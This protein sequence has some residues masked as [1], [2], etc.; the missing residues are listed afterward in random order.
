MTVW[1]SSDHINDAERLTNNVLAD[2]NS[3]LHYASVEEIEET[4][5]WLR[6]YE[7]GL[8]SCCISWVDCVR[9]PNSRF[10]PKMDTCTSY[11]VQHALVLWAYS[12]HVLTKSWYLSLKAWTNF[13]S[14]N[15]D[16]TCLDFRCCIWQQFGGHD[17]TCWIMYCIT[18]A[19][20]SITKLAHIYMCLALVCLSQ[21]CKT[22][23][24]CDCRIFI[25]SSRVYG[26]WVYIWRYKLFAICYMFYMFSA[27]SQLRP[28]VVW[29]YGSRYST[30]VYRV[31]DLEK[32][33]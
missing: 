15:V 12:C 19:C 11:T 23:S 33:L 13:W 32:E 2:H 24:C 1:K 26:R 16:V 29:L 20:K 8:D 14:H 28:V 10:F 17:V 25:R 31:K 5:S 9:S 22:I 4:S 7:I 18:C 30:H 21:I 27:D 6:V 3:S